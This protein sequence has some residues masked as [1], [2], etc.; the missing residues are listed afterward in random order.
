MYNKVERKI[1][2]ES[3]RKG[4]EVIRPGSVTIGV[5]S[6]EKGDYMGGLFPRE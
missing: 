1:Q 2:A 3:G 4:R 5:K 6:E